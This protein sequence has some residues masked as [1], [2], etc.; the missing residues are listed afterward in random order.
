MKLVTKSLVLVLV[1]VLMLCAVP[2]VFA[3]EPDGSVENPYAWDG[4]GT[5]TVTCS[6]DKVT[7]YSI[8]AGG[9][10]INFEAATRG[11][12]FS[13]SY[14]T[15]S[16]SLFPMGAPASGSKAFAGL[17]AGAAVVIGLKFNGAEGST[18]DLKMTVGEIV[19]GTYELPLNLNN[20]GPGANNHFFDVE[21]PET[22]TYYCTYTAE[23][24]G[25][26][27]IEHVTPEGYYQCGIQVISPD[28]VPVI[29]GDMS[30]PANPL[31]SWS[32]KKGDTYK[33][34]FGGWAGDK[35]SGVVINYETKEEAVS[36]KKTNLFQVPVNAGK[37]ISVMDGSTN[38]MWNGK[39]VSISCADPDV[40]A[41]TSVIYNGVTYIDQDMNGII[42]ITMDDLSGGSVISRNE[43]TIVNGSEDD[44][45]YNI[46]IIDMLVAEGACKHPGLE[47]E[48]G[49][50]AC[51][52]D[53]LKENWYCANCDKYWS[54]ED[55]TS[56]IDEADLVIP[57]TTELVHHEKV[58]ACHVNGYEEYWECTKCETLYKKADGTGLCS[59]KDVTI[60]A[61]MELTH[62]EAKESEC[63][64]AGNIEYWYCEG[65]GGHYTHADGTGVTNAKNVHT[66]PEVTMEYTAAVEATCHQNGM[67]EYWYCKECDTYSADPYGN[68]PVAYLSLTQL[69]TAEIEHHEA[70]DATAKENGNH[71]YWICTECHTVFTDAALTKVSNIK[72]VTIPAT[73]NPDTGD[74]CIELIATVAIVSMGAVLVLGK[75]KFF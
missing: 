71:E 70:K 46:E 21:I 67:A 27:V 31:I 33:I 11:T 68:Q 20:A 2:A 57:A 43:M 53:G 40:L 42:T 5:K 3:A 37:E 50:D 51:H 55:C 35:I 60:L 26:I 59:I 1:L 54:D 22:G 10:Q 12:A 7:Y 49:Y 39:G 75:K 34:E 74:V 62:V 25:V 63:H 41:A 48:V 28:D 52:N 14:G 61:N 6:A 66:S 4:T 16:M 45:I 58:D 69:A 38:P 9:K 47:H 44:V 15:E 18:A 72:N 36:I 8:P 32:V 65:C 30:E 24:D 13:V 17:E 19:Y 73:S 29:V 64:E 23:V 56:A